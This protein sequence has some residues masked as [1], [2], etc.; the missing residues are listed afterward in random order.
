ML[1]FNPANPREKIHGIFDSNIGNLF[2][3]MGL[4]DDVISGKILCYVCKETISLENF[5]AVIRNN[6][7]LHFYCDKPLC[8]NFMDNDQ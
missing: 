5:G 7:E 6:S 2:K 8:Q 3:K 1:K 4:E